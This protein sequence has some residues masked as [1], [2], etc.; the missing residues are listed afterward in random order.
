[1]NVEEVE[2][3]QRFYGLPVT[4]TVDVQT[5]WAMSDY[6]WNKE[7]G[8]AWIVMPVCWEVV[9]NELVS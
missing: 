9:N 2:A 4:G 1:M 8:A 5:R 7:W 6:R 3:I